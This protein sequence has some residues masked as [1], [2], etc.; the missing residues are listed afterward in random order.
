MNGVR[1]HLLV[2]TTHGVGRCDSVADVWVT[3]QAAGP[4]RDSGGARGLQST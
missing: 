4:R 3:L 2:V 1:P